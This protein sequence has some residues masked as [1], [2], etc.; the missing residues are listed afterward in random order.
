MANLF[1]FDFIDPLSYLQEIELIAVGSDVERVGFELA[2]PP[3]PLTAVTDARWKERWTEA[4]RLAGTMGVPL[5]SPSL[6]PWSRKAHEL[7]LHAKEDGRGDEVRRGIFE[8]Y[9]GRG[10]DSGR[11]DRLVAVAVSVGIDRT[12]V[13]AALDVD[14]HQQGVLEARRS[15]AEAGIADTPAIVV[16]GRVLRGFH[17]R[18]ALGT[19]SRGA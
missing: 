18:A 14:R 5:A 19:L 12:S 7:H 15:A 1:Y 16:A 2:P 13:K 3:E 4:H 6:V 17:N 11:V 9:F 10:E 8:A